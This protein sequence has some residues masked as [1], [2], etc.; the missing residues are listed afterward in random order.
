VKYFSS[1]TCSLS[2]IHANNISWSGAVPLPLT[3]PAWPLSC[4]LF[5]FFFFFLSP[6]GLISTAHWPHLV[7][8]TIAYVSSWF[9]DSGMLACPGDS[10]SQCSS[11]SCLLPC[12]QW[13]ESWILVVAHSS[14][15][16]K[17][18]GAFEE[19]GNNTQFLVISSKVLS[20]QR[21][22]RRPV[23]CTWD[24]PGASIQ[25]HLELLP[26]F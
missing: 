25:R 22:P 14:L 10:T 9:G 5:F 12:F 26:S 23:K 21:R 6:L 11:S 1:L 7:R 19:W 24:S 8:V 16:Q 4:P 13:W 15:Y 17:L 2:F 3:L 18:V 20:H